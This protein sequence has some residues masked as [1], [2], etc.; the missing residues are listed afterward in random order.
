M[1]L[2]RQHQ[3][4]RMLVHKAEVPGRSDTARRTQLV[5]EEYQFLMLDNM[6]HTA[7]SRTMPG[8]A[9]SLHY[10]LGLPGR[11]WFAWRVQPI[12]AQGV[13]FKCT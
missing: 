11:A 8:A 7:G 12:A 10:S 4:C 5:D 6:A 9:C 2:L 3:P 1:Y 13:S